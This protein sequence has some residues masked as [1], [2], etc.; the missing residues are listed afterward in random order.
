MVGEPVEERGCHLCIAEHAWPFAEGQVGGDDDRG[1]LIELTD[2]VEQKLTA[3]LR[4]GQ[5][6]QLIQDQEV[7]A[8]DQVS[9][10]ALPLGT[11]FCI[12]LVH[13]IDDIEEPAP[14]SGPDAG[15]GDA[16]GKMGF[17]GSGAADQDEVPLMV[18]EVTSCQVA[19]QRLVDLRRLEVELFQFFGQGQFGN[20]HLV[21]DR[22]GL[23]LADLGS[24][25]IPDDLLR[26][27]LAFDSGG[28]DLVIRCSHSVELQ[29]SHRVDHV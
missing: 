14:S 13:E 21:F 3:G 25:Q 22:A 26:L 28:Q 23:L 27:M 4:K 2:Q 8:G 6:T 17:A 24:E 7:E 18:E 19:D 20:G 16:N 5:I 1:A 15:A 29:L 11:G 10:S 12:E 9:G